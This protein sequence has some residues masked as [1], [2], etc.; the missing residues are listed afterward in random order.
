MNIYYLLSDL[1]TSL[2]QSFQET[3]TEGITSFYQMRKLR[4]KEIK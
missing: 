2:Q 1:N 3:L 4:L